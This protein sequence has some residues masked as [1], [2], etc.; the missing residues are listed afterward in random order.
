MPYLWKLNFIPWAMAGGIESLIDGQNDH[1]MNC[2][3]KNF[4]PFPTFLGPNNS[5]PPLLPWKHN[6]PPPHPIVLNGHFLTYSN[7][8]C[9]P[10][11]DYC[12]DSSMPFFL[13]LCNTTWFAVMFSVRGS[14]GI[15]LVNGPPQYE[16]KEGFPRLVL[17]S[18]PCSLAAFATQFKS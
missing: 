3:D 9:F 8:N 12:L 15:H 10:F 14:S 1:F 17:L 11:P 13:F 4:N 6:L 5:P 16:D 7:A 18:Y 2:L